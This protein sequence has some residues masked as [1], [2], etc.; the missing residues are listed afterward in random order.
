MGIANSPEIFQQ[1]MNNLFHGFEFIHLYVYKIFIFTNG[2]WNY[3]VYELKLI[4]N[5]MKEKYLKCDIEKYFFGLSKEMI[6][7]VKFESFFLQ[8]IYG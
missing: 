3:H 2:D 6:F 8:F 7:N 5:K 1:K 4:L